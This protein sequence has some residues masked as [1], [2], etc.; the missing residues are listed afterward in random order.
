M[1]GKG[2]GKILSKFCTTGRNSRLTLLRPHQV[3]DTRCKDGKILNM[4][5]DDVNFV[6][7]HHLTPVVG[8]FKKVND[9][10]DVNVDPDLPKIDRGVKLVRFFYP[11]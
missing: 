5:K 6:Y 11:V 4:L 8:E 1:N 10:Q 7:F 2:R 9:F 3:A